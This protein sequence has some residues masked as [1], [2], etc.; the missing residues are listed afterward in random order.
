MTR[1][2]NIKK[3]KCDVY[4]GRRRAGRDGYFGSPIVIGSICP[5]CNNIHND[6]GSTLPCYKIYFQRRLQD[7]QMFKEMVLQ[8]KGKKLGCFCAP[9]PCHG[10]VI[11]EYLGD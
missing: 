3:E 4:I 6:A 5:I 11:A 7:D 2:V 1:V 10:N 9:G 8:L